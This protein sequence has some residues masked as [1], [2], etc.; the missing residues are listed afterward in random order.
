MH[1]FTIDPG[2]PGTLFTVVAHSN[3][4][5]LV[6]TDRVGEQLAIDIP[7]ADSWA[8]QQDALHERWHKSGYDAGRMDA[9]EEVVAEAFPGGR[10]YHPDQ[11]Y[12]KLLNIRTELQER[13]KQAVEEKIRNN[14]RREAEL[15]NYTPTPEEVGD[16]LREA[17][18][19]AEWVEHSGEVAPMYPHMVA[20]IRKGDQIG[21]FGAHRVVDSGEPEKEAEPV[22]HSVGTISISAEEYNANMNAAREEG[23]RNALAQ[24]IGRRPQVTTASLRMIVHEILSAHGNQPPNTLTA[25]KAA[26][27]RFGVEVVDNG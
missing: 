27:P 1:I 15:E 17:G 12:A 18:V 8:T 4:E 19:P 26:L 14:E 5:K 23:E 24:P 13:R 20:E 2:I 7:D 25:L 16:A 22:V 6:I 9:I 11:A 10:N 21:T 3:E